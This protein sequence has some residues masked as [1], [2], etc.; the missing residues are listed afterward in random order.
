MNKKIK[1]LFE[2]NLRL[3]FILLVIFAAATF[4]LGEYSTTL[5]IAEACIVVIVLI[6]YIYTGRRRNKEILNYIE[7]LT[8]NVDSA[9]KDNLVNFPMPMAIF[10]LDDTEIV[11]ANDS[12]L[13]MTGEHEH[14]FQVRLSDIVPSLPTKW[15]MEGKSECPV[16]VPVLDKLY[17]VYGNVVRVAQNSDSRSLLAT[18][19]WLDVTETTHLAE[20]FAASRLV[21]AIIMLDNYDEF[22]NGL[23]D[24]DK[25]SML[26]M[27]DDRISDWAG[28][29]GGYLS[30]YDR[31][32]YI[33]LFEERF[34]KGF[35][36]GRFSLLDSV[37]E[38]MSPK[39]ISATLSIGVGKDGKT[40]A[41]SY[42]FASLS[43][44]MA[45]SRGGD[46]AVIKN[47]FNFEFFGGKTSQMEKRTKVKSRVMA[48][49][50]SELISD[51]SRVFIMGHK[52]ADLDSVGAAVGI[53]CAARKRGKQANIVVDMT[54]NASHELINRMLSLPEYAD[55]FISPEAAILAADG[56]SLL[57]VV[58]TNR[59]EQ[60]ESEAL[61]LSCNRV[62]VI[63]H[64]R[65]ASTYIQD[66]ALSFHEP[67]ASSA[68]ELVTELLQYIVEP[69]DILRF[70]AE[71]LLAGIV[72]DTKNFTLRTGG[73]T[74]D[75]AAF[76]RR[77][78][79]DTAE[80][81]RLLQTDIKTAMQRYA[82]IQKAKVYKAG[83]AIAAPETTEDR[84]IAAQAADELLNISGIKASFVVFASGDTVNISARAVGDINVQVIV[85]K[86]GGGGNK[87]T[88]GAQIQ[89]KTLKEVVGSLLAAIDEYL[90]S[91]SGN[92]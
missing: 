82:I 67:Y 77:S 48:N 25:S 71:A 50:L 87:A 80:V 88:A 36:D 64:H 61:L 63:D 26:A 90:E 49:S 76:L 83:I 51:A 11:T 24:K 84:I 34:L 74:F 89:G 1:R 73:R 37:R 65:R 27:I 66:A 38:V 85:E 29:C 68:S 23:S 2:P 30:K 78:G 14:F 70:E 28:N 60:V 7:N 52:Y 10:N 13:K 47:R 22:S 56:N 42:Q 39:G 86:L 35:I 62:A 81:K 20:E 3:Y 69:A 72:L 32:R 92:A 75:A 15:L 45:L 91:N 46:Q 54:A 55:T 4:F 58:D 53:C 33:F 17:K 40:L 31:D 18:T 79:A 43:I 19:Y 59:P 6:I 44:D 21:F 41:E 57:V 12:F 9:A 16:P 8:Y 5:A